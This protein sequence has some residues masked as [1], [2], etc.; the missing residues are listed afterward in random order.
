MSLA[1]VGLSSGSLEKLIVTD[2]IQAATQPWCP[3]SSSAE[4]SCHEAGCFRQVQV[5]RLAAYTAGDA[6]ASDDARVAAV[7]RPTSCLQ[8]AGFEVLQPLF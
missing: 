6:G 2:P 8:R 3:M 5:A 7:D 1:L 4:Q